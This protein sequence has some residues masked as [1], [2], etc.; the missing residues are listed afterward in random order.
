MARL[1]GV[2]RMDEEGGKGQRSWGKTKSKSEIGAIGLGG[3]AGRIQ[4]G[5]WVS[6]VGVPTYKWDM[7]VDSQRHQYMMKEVGAPV[8]ASALAQ[9]RRQVCQEK[10]G[11]L[12]LCK[13]V[14][15]V[16]CK[17]PTEG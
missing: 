16:A 4:G 7:V 15:N 9:V 14:R 2:P 5:R 3:G 13:R 10:A 6:D 1:F 11:E 12:V 8:T 17:A